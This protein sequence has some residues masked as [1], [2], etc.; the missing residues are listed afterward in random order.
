MVPGWGN[1]VSSFVLG[2]LVPRRLAIRVLSG[3]L[4]S[5]YEG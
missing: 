2:R 3:L 5:L 1:R 4:E